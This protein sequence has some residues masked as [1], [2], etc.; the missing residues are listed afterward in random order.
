[1]DIA[2]QGVTTFGNYTAPAIAVI[3]HF[4]PFSNAI[5]R[6]FAYIGGNFG[7]T[8]VSIVTGSLNGELATGEVHV[9][10][11]NL[12]GTDLGAWAP[13]WLGSVPKLIGTAGNVLTAIKGTSESPNFMVVDMGG[14][15]VDPSD[16][17]SVD[18]LRRTVDRQIV[19]QFG[20]APSPCFAAGTPIW[21][22]DGTTRPIEDIKVGDLVLAFD[23]N[24]F[25]GRG[26]LRPRRVTR[27]FRN[28]T[29]HWLL[30][31]S[32]RVRGASSKTIAVTSAHRFL[33]TDGAFRRIDEIIA[34]DSSVLFADGTVDLVSA[35]RV[36]VR[37]IASMGLDSGAHQQSS[38]ACDSKELEQISWETYNFEVEE[39]HT[40]IAAG[41]RVH[42][43]CS[44]TLVI[45]PDQFSNLFGHQFDGSASDI[46]AALQAIADGQ[47]STMGQYLA[48][49]D[50]ER[51]TASFFTQSENRIAISGDA[52]GWFASMVS[53][54]EVDRIVQTS[55]IG[56][57]VDTK[58]DA[59]GVI[60]LQKEVNASGE[61]LLKYYDTHN[62]HPYSELDV[63]KDPNGNITS[64]TPK[65]D[66]IVI[67]AGG[68]IGQIFGSAIGRSIAGDNAFA[69]LAA[70]T[71][72]GYIGQQLGT[73]VATALQGD[74]S[75][76]NF[77]EA[78]DHFDVNI[79]GAAAGSVASFL[80]AEL[81]TALGLSGFGAQLFNA[82]VGAYA[83]SVLSQVVRTSLSQGV[84]AIS[85]TSAFD[86][87]IPSVSSAIGSMLASQI[88]HAENLGGAIGGQI[89]GAVGGLIGL[90]TVGLSAV[91]GV[92]V[93]GIGAFMGTILGTI[94]GDVIGAGDK[95]PQAYHSVLQGEHLYLT[96]LNHVQDGGDASV[97]DAMGNAA[98]GMANAYLS[99][100]DGVA[101]G[102]GIA[103]SLIGYVV[104]S[105]GTA[106]SYQ[107]SYDGG[108]NFDY[109]R[110]AD[111]AVQ[112][113]APHLLQGTEAIGGNLLLK[114][115]HHNGNAA[116]M[117]TLAGDLQVAQD[118]E[119]YLDNREVINALIAAN[120]NTAFTEGWAATFARVQDL[121]LSHY[122][123][124]DF[125]G[126]MVTGYLDS[127]RKA[128]LSFSLAD[129]SMKHGGDGSATIA[130]HVPG[131]VDI[132]G[133]L[134]VFAS[135]TD[136]VDDATGKSVQLVFT[137]GLAAAGFHGPA[138]STISNGIQMVTASG[139]SNIWFGRDDVPNNFYGV[140]ASENIVVGGS[141]NDV[142]S[143]GSG[144]DFM[145]GGD[146]NDNLYGGYGNDVLRGGK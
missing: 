114:R 103:S 54:G 38:P 52:S 120:P 82:S 129:S 101:I 9:A 50:M 142:M 31:S 140:A 17:L 94:L 76:F 60:E 51:F 95:Y 128:G 6:D 12:G 33:S 123:A 93:P 22:A 92:I 112:S 55:N 109:F 64:A 97:S 136:V 10:V 108:Q 7:P 99:A 42:N 14:G 4:D 115:A 45:S 118:Y 20:E 74:F 77:A 91:L 107:A 44:P 124:V 49:G 102:P 35:R 141:L 56:N 127:V 146:G 26:P 48:T 119:R 71:V 39:L 104:V 16:Q 110:T 90:T 70:G 134:S 116:D 83:G 53:N 62:T 58:F 67:G 23:S 11:Y 65:L 72:G 145:D 113:F 79:A 46:D 40:Y 98:V 28:V 18:T 66:P 59:D 1:M 131:N 135:H 63:S 32:K 125:L 122:G 36:S 47:L 96:N 8:T 41:I 105:N 19:Q 87:A 86:N 57:T 138:S 137:D 2:I 144:A 15:V 27:L 85:W 24:E 121:G 88:V 78:F 34:G 81:G 143:G 117:L 13:K 100:V 21:L 30:L 80:T 69:Q 130:I 89:G 61:Q 3:E 132:P 68:S 84:G 43:D 133:A 29:D 106:V 37:E 139:G 25:L 73:Q 5:V 111:E 75:G 126:G